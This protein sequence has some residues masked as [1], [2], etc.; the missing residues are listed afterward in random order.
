MVSLS[1]DSLKQGCA[2]LN[3]RI[4]ECEDCK[5]E[6]LLQDLAEWILKFLVTQGFAVKQTH[7]REYVGVHPCK[8]I[9]QAQKE[10]M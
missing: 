6:G 4:D 3:E 10:L 1:E 2:M 8:H 7:R 9:A 5:D